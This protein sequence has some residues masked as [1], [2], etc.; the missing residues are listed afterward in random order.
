MRSF[1]LIE[2]LDDSYGGPAKSVP[3]LCKYLQDVGVSA[4]SLSIQYHG[5]ESNEVIKNNDLDWHSFSFNY[6]K[7][8]RYSAA[9]KGY[10]DKVIP[11]SN[12]IVLHTHNLWNYIPYIANVFSKKYKIP[13]IMS[14]RGSLYP[15]SLKQ[16]KFQKLLVWKLFQRRILN[17]AACIH[18]T[19]LAEI[20]A[21]RDL[22]ITSPIAF[23]PNGIEL[24]EF[25]VM[26]VSDVAKTN[27]GLE[28]N[29]KYILFLSRV[30]PKKGLEFLVNGWIK[31]AKNNKEWD[32]LIVGPIY[33][34][35]YLDNINGLLSQ[36]GL[37]NRVHFKGMLS[38]T[39]RIDAFAASELFVLPSHTEN[40]GISI[41]EALAAKLPVI[42]TKGT[43]WKEIQEHN[44]GWWVTLNQA[45]IDSALS[46]A[47]SCSDEVLKQKGLN[48]FDFIKN[49]EWKYQAEKMKLLYLYVLNQQ[50]KPDFVYEVGDDAV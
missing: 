49:Y 21:I 14:V 4:I 46:E 11:I 47:L 40:F 5:H 42:T 39:S 33:D 16:S 27:L 12:N 41:A 7:K 24:Q 2:N 20:K 26:N 15:W 22:G 45:N 31:L 32:L 19:D 18:A 10:L 17:E 23:I 35:T 13:I 9:L 6:I 37:Q 8:I 28:K 30:H 50:N 48:G 43:P 44:A 1:H 34:E 38:G 25:E 29:K 36:H 3:Y